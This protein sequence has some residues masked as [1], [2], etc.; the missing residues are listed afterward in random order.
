MAL[1]AT[2]SGSQP[3]RHEL[4]VQCSLPFDS[5]RTAV[6]GVFRTV[7]SDPSVEHAIH[8]LEVACYAAGIW[9]TVAG[10]SRA[11]SRQS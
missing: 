4:L 3:A 11:L 8:V 1:L 10:R 9:R 2:T 5:V 7:G 6:E